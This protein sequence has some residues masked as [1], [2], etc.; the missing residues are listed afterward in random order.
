MAAMGSYYG[1]LP[2]AQGFNPYLLTFQP[3]AYDFQGYPGVNPYGQMMQGNPAYGQPFNQW[4][5]AAMY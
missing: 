4:A 1:P 2:T 5:A 3:G